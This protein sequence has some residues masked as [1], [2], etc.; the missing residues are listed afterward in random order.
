M[1]LQAN[2]IWPM[3]ALV[4]IW[5]KRQITLVAA[6][7]T[8][9]VLSGCKAKPPNDTKL[10]ISMI[11]T[12]D[13]GKAL[14]ENQPLL[15]YWQKQTG[16]T[17]ELTIPT[18]YA[19]VVEA[20]ANNKVDIAYLGGFTYVQ[21]SARVGVKPLV[22]RAI[23]QQFHSV[24]IT[25][26]D[27]K[28]HS[29]A[30]LHGH[31]V[32]GDVNSTSGHLMPLYYMQQEKVDPDVIKNASYSGAHDATALAVA[33]GK[34]EAG[35]MD[36]QVYKKMTANGQLKPDTVRV[37]YTTPPFF[38]YV[39]VANKNLDAK[40][41]DSFADAMKGLSADNPEQKTLLDLLNA[42]GY[43]TANDADYGKLREAA[44]SAGLLH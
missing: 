37:F 12:T 44:Q 34:A 43:V 13:P 27:S 22:Q 21:A 23:D 30:D 28:I 19:A 20:L 18:S 16:R 11:P 36:E 38:D 9:S 6:V 33:N 24:F 32:F 14:R 41:A 42:K 29:L 25:Q 31:F 4:S 39:W 26:T 15:A 2:G 1:T 3:D 8:V 17:P 7:L 10:L 5:N 35:S 40:T